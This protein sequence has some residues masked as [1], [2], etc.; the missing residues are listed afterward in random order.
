MS[1][2]QFINEQSHYTCTFKALIHCIYMYVYKSACM[3]HSACIHEYALKHM[4][5]HTNTT[6][7]TVTLAQVTH[8]FALTFTH[9]HTRTHTH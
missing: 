2:Y 4:N 7:Y 9:T 8:T 6:T 1:I 5:A 3:C